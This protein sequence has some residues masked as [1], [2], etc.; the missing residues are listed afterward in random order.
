MAN[1]M[2]AM[3]MMMGGGNAAAVDNCSYL[4]FGDSDSHVWLDGWL[5]GRLQLPVFVRLNGIRVF[6]HLCVCTQ[7]PIILKRVSLCDDLESSPPPPPTTT[8]GPL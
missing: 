2:M 7:L 5:V 1:V 4:Y 3:M 8:S 6:P